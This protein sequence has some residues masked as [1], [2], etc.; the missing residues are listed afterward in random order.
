MFCT[1][2]FRAS[3]YHD[4][5][6]ATILHYALLLHCESSALGK[7]KRCILKALQEDNSM[8][9]HE[10]ST[11]KRMSFSCLSQVSA[12]SQRRLRQCSSSAT[13]SGAP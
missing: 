12:R 11:V 5:F 7:H 4:A 3:L 1:V 8:T 6:Y 10:Y 2:V 13:G 9:A